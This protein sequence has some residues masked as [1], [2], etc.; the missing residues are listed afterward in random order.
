MGRNK[1]GFKIKQGY[2]GYVIHVYAN[3]SHVEGKV[4]YHYQIANGGKTMASS[5][6][7]DSTDNFAAA[8]LRALEIVDHRV[9]LFNSALAEDL[10]RPY[11]KRLNQK[12]RETHPMGKCGQCGAKDH[13]MD[14]WCFT[15][16]FLD[17]HFS[18][19]DK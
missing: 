16:L 9:S 19:A 17:G 13:V 11:T 5:G 6:G 4:K 18:N 8:M 12:F 7:K 2:R 15:C 14:G 1:K 10:T 3:Y